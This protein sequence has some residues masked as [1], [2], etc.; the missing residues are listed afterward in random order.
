M[1]NMAWTWGYSDC[2]PGE[3]FL[4][5]AHRWKGDILPST[6]V[7]CKPLQVLC[8]NVESR[9]RNHCPGELRDGRLQATEAKDFS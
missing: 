7:P 6:K 3:R 2:P 4:P 1:V 9:L 8:L 5:P